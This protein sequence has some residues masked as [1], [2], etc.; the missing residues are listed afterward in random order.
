[1]RQNQ[2]YRVQDIFIIKHEEL[3]K[4]L[5]MLTAC[6]LVLLTLTALELSCWLVLPMITALELACWLVLPMIMALEWHS[7]HLNQHDLWKALQAQDHARVKEQER[8]RYDIQ[9]KNL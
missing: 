7:L 6:W 9:G 1:L 3:T 5:S 2:Q 8:N 4:V